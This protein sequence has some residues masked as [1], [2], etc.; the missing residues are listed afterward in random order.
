MQKHKHA[1]K[2]KIF[3]PLFVNHQQRGKNQ[4]KTKS[5]P[6]FNTKKQS[7]IKG[8]SKA[9]YANSQVGMFPTCHRN[10]TIMDI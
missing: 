9:K 4:N 6:L 2:L 10:T 1:Y 7:S 5:S 8:K 3:L